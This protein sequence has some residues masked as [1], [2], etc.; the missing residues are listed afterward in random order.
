MASAVDK[1]K[2]RGSAVD[3]SAAASS[4]DNGVHEN[5]ADMGPDA[6]CND[7][8]TV[9]NSPWSSERGGGGSFG[10]YSQSLRAS[11]AHGEG[12]VGD[13]YGSSRLLTSVGLTG[14]PGTAPE[15][16]S[17]NG[18][19]RGRTPLLRGDSDQH[20][21]G[22]WQWRS[23]SP[24][25]SVDRQK[26]ED[27]RQEAA[28]AELEV[29]EDQQGGEAMVTAAAVAGTCES[30]MRTG[31]DLPDSGGGVKPGESVVRASGGYLP[32]RHPLATVVSVSPEST[33]GDVLGTVPGT[34]TEPQSDGRIGNV[35]GST[36][37]SGS[38]ANED[39]EGDGA[40]TL[41]AAPQRPGLV[42]RGAARTRA[43]G[44]VDGGTQKKP[45]ELPKPVRVEP[46]SPAPTEEE[47][48]RR[49]AGR[50][51]PRA[52]RSSE[53]DGAGD[54]PT[55]AS[56]SE[57]LSGFADWLMPGMEGRRRAESDDEQRRLT[58]RLSRLSPPGTPSR[59]GT[60]SAPVTPRGRA[61]AKSALLR[62]GGWFYN[63]DSDYSSS[64]E[65]SGF[66]SDDDE[67]FWA[68]AGT[69]EPGAP[70]KM[71]GGGGLSILERLRRLFT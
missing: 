30:P 69:T 37:G 9:C 34:N 31:Q 67:G 41:D 3:P 13:G 49:G 70:R 24:P 46:L 25:A 28:V 50:K 40:P 51:K 35:N 11:S 43:K 68:D 57:V 62:E 16:S 15:T 19:R 2:K 48:P 14:G 26:T 59:K 27:I 54:S 58:P 23:Y 29:S 20:K 65:M 61:K 47:G 8:S 10:G 44:P 63:G 60:K 56:I 52:R 5:G 66:D 71:G 17:R 42:A 21:R 22:W 12:D 1:R 18:T 53:G 32:P 33:P 64:D 6:S 38:V 7:D 39:G 4:H 55:P 36:N 45:S